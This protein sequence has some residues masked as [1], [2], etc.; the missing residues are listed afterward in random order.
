MEKWKGQNIW[1]KHTALF[2][3][4]DKFLQ[5]SIKGLRGETESEIIATHD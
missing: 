4:E 5:L 1:S 3:K 2:I